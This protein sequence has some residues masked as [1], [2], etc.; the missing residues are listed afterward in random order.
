MELQTFNSTQFG[1]LRTAEIE[2][3]IY[4]CGN[5]VA[6]A[7]GYIRPRDAVAL[8]CKGAVK[9]RTPTNGGVQ[10]LSF[11]PE[12]DVYRLAARSKLP[13]AE[14][15]E[16]WV[17][18]EVLPQINHTGGYRVPQNPMEALQLMFDAQKN[19]DM[20]VT[21][22][23]EDVENRF[24][25]LPLV[26]DEPEEIVSEVNAIALKLLGGKKSNAYN[27][28][29]LRSRVYQDIWHE[30]KHKFGVRK[31]KAIKRKYIPNVKAVLEAYTCP[32]NLLEEILAVNQQDVLCGNT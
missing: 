3:K 1:E 30:V 16:S 26:G 21:N 20:R 24:Q 10:E 12:G 14:K 28:K 13:Q 27:D 7:L 15:F 22:L 23:K 17:F 6:R 11:I 29:S 19:T 25:D 4:Y 9:H 8:H 31:Y 2:G 32:Q 18:D 5:D